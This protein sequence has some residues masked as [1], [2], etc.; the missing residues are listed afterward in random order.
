MTDDLADELEYREAMG[1]RPVT[2]EK[3]E[4]CLGSLGYVLDRECDCLGSARYMTGP[5]SGK[6][7][8]G[9]STGINERD[10]GRSAFHVDA[11]RDAAFRTLQRLRFEVGLYAVVDGAIMDI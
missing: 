8:P 3:I 9:L 10:T 4:R 7:Y 2:L 6:S 11:R 1:W 5:W